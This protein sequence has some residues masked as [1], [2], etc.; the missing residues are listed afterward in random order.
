MCDGG[1]VRDCVG[2]MPA[3]TIETEWELA[4]V[5][6]YLS[7]GSGRR[8]GVLPPPVDPPLRLL[9]LLLQAGAALPLVITRTQGVNEII[10]PDDHPH[11]LVGPS[12]R[13]LQA[14]IQQ[15]FRLGV[16]GTSRLAPL[17]G[18]QASLEAWQL[19]DMCAAA[20]FGHRVAT[21]RP[22][23]EEGISAS[24]PAVV[25]LVITH[26]EQPVR[27]MRIL[28]S[29]DGQVLPKEV[30]LEVVMVDE[31]SWSAEA[32]EAVAALRDPKG[33]FFRNRGKVVELQG[34]EAGAARNEGWRNA[35]G[36]YVVFMDTHNFAKPFLIGTLLRV[37]QRMGAGVVTSVG[38]YAPS[39][40]SELHDPTQETA[41]LGR[42]TPLGS[43][44]AAGGVASV[45]GGSASLFSRAAL[46]QLGG[47]PVEPDYA[48]QEW[49]MLTR[50][51]LLELK[52][53]V[54]AEPLFWR[55]IPENVP[56][57][58]AATSQALRVRPFYQHL[59]TFGETASFSIA[60]HSRIQEM[61][62]RM[63]KMD[64]DG[65]TSKL[66]MESMHRLHCGKTATQ[67]KKLNVTNRVLNPSFSEW[68]KGVADGWFPHGRGY[69]IEEGRPLGKRKKVRPQDKSVRVVLD[70][71]AEEAG[72]TQHVYIGQHKAESLLLQGW[73]F[74]EEIS[75]IGNKNDY[76]LYADV[77]FV[78]GTRHWGFALPFDS[79]IVGWQQVHGVIF[80]A[81][82]VLRVELFC[83]LRWRIGVVR[84]DDI[85]ISSLD[86]GICGVDAWTVESE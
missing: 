36:S 68:T 28:R 51:G 24:V 46:L 43:A 16:K 3:I 49:E 47:W 84:F 40:E 27:L 60:A 44:L 78:D 34:V 41:P 20:R 31:G 38:D 11:V 12:L 8:V 15:V 21:N 53:E 10:H 39:Q 85:S 66:L 76:A 82:P 57:S 83:I 30:E 5:V 65:V 81:T 25:S 71:G 58:V 17:R 61:E 6:T 42:F 19:W 22:T 52:V 80:A 77:F 37:A 73:S 70:N 54:V 86:D 69:K 72:A 50:A 26:Y 63:V 13:L 9:T 7:D 32:L 33:D 48:A 64:A 29:I 79:S 75:A 18:S 1:R 74:V 59:G 56:Q 62:E 67:H 4:T 2:H 23:H 14:K 55:A 35:L 45:F